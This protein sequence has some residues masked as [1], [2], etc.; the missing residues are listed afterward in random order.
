MAEGIILTAGYA[1]RAQSN[2]ML[3]EIDK[4]KM[5]YHAISSMQPHV[6]HIYVVTGYYHKE[7]HNALKSLS[8]VTCVMNTQ[9][10]KGMFSSVQAGVRMTNEDFFILP[11]DCPFVS[12]QTYENLLKGRKEIRI[13]S[14]QGRRGHPIFFKK[15]FKRIILE[16]DQ[17][18]NLKR[19]RN[20]FDFETIEGLDVNILNDVDTRNDLNQLIKQRSIKNGN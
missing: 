2:K 5:I 19:I 18:S 8:D 12:K 3:F 17:T 13:P 16:E 14:Y 4:T 6:S 11:G 15:K 7:I 10:E 20:R 1:S 9:F